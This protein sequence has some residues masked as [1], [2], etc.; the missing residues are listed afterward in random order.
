VSAAKLQ[1]FSN[2]P[3][4]G[5]SDKGCNSTSRRADSGEIVPE[6]GFP[7]HKLVKAATINEALDSLAANP[8]LHD[9]PMGW[10]AESDRYGNWLAI[11]LHPPGNAF[12]EVPNL[13]DQLWAVITSQNGKLVIL[14][15][16]HVGLLPSS[17]MGVL[18]RIHK[19]LAIA[20]GVLHLCCLNHHCR[21]ALHVCHLDRVLP[22]F[23]DRDAAARGAVEAEFP[24]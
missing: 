5:R 22:V 10:R 20:G 6:S 11:N 19:R 9:L 8:M 2:L 17:L 15:M 23:T 12:I 14:D 7:K 18:V 24:A 1:E 3:G 4:Q 16:Y 21:E 13:A